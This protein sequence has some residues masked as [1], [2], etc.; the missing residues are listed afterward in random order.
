[1]GRRQE[2]RKVSRISVGQGRLWVSWEASPLDGAVV[3]VDEVPGLT[4]QLFSGW[5]TLAGPALQFPGKYKGTQAAS[6]GARSILVQGVG[7]TKVR[8]SP[9][10]AQGAEAGVGLRGRR[11]LQGGS[12]LGPTQSLGHGCEVEL[13]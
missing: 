10:L 7:S 5:S 2:S 13:A 1:M 4:Q 11:G 8:V 12:D 3:L 6:L 9:G